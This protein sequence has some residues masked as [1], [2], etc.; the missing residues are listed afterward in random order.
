[1]ID[2]FFKFFSKSSFLLALAFLPNVPQ[3]VKSSNY[4]A[5]CCVLQGIRPNTSWVTSTTLQGSK[6]E[7]HCLYSLLSVCAVSFTS[8]VHGRRVVL[9]KE[10]A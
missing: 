3:Q 7:V 9:E 1:V 10:M 2:D 4:I 5:S 8:W 6:H